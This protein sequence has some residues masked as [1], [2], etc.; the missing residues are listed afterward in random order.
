MSQQLD[1]IP[2]NFL[3]KWQGIADL[4]A[5]VIDVPAALIMKTDNEF[6]EV[7][8]SSQSENNP[9][10]PGDK[11][12]WYGL[13]CETVIKTQKALLVPNALKDEKWNKNPDIKLGMISYLGVP[14]NYPDKQPFGTLCVLDKKENKFSPENKALLYQFKN[15]IELDLALIQSLS[16]NSSIENIDIVQKLKEQNEE[17]LVINEELQQSNNQ[18]L[19]KKNELNESEKQFR[20]IV[21][22]APE[23]IFIQTEM[24][25]AYINK[26]GLELFGAKA[27]E[28]LLGTKI[29]DRVYEDNKE[30]A[31]QRITNLNIHKK[32]QSSL[33]QVFVKL[34]GTKVAVETVGIPYKYKGKDGALVF[35]RDVTERKKAEEKLQKQSEEY[36]AL[37]EEYKTQNEEISEA[38]E[39]VEKSEKKLRHFHDLM[40]YIIEHSRSAIAVHDKNYRYIYVSQR[41]LQDYK[42]KEKDIIGKH[43]YEVFPDLPQKWREVHKK[44]LAGEVSSAEDDPYYKEDGTIEWTRW[45]CRPWYEEDHSIGGFIV[46]TEVITKQKNFELELKNAK[47]KAEEANRL[48]TE[49]LN[50][51][52]HEIRTPMNGIIGFSELL[53]EP[54][55]NDEQRKYHIKIIQNSCHQLLRII[56]DILAISKL[57]TRQEKLNETEFCFND[58][59]MEI[60]SIFNLKSKERK[61]PV[62]VYKELQ[63]KESYVISDKAKLNTILSNL[64]ENAIRFTSQ[65]FIEFGYF[66]EK[67][68]LVLY[69]KDTGIGIAPENHKIIFE[70]FSQED[71]ELSRKYGGLG[72]GLSIA[73]EN[74][75]LL[76]GDITLESEKGKG[77]TFYVTIPYKPVNRTS[78]GQKKDSPNDS[79]RLHETTI[80]I[81]EDEEINF[82]YLEIL[83]NKQSQQKYHIIRAK[84]GREA[85]DICLKN[86]NIQLVLMDLKMPV[87]NGLEA[88]QKIKSKFPDLPVIAQT[89]Y[90]TDNDKDLAL[91]YG[92]DDF[93]SKPIKK[94]S[95]FKLINKYLNTNYLQ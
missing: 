87:M 34:D 29:L 19:I 9:Y 83:F 31:G 61:F 2:D 78:G 55:L 90:S 6:M 68:N 1:D 91:E 10:H 28:Q 81:A 60:F 46:Y 35:A 23:A 44:A 45:E 33:N 69:V 75:L 57:E 51:M 24:K 22:N 52:S 25:F 72:L 40:Q 32:V 95:L 27:H 13:Y 73:K 20:Q 80:L 41:Y 16:L 84:D 43:H 14:I 93:I 79:K 38:K 15:V 4:L 67:T 36:Y 77:A 8:I 70:R 11:E 21:E 62:Y 86:R 94:E 3:E 85:Y 71:K 30:E 39:R 66:I 53:D 54:E 76:G 12:Q 56:D 17:Y 47:E 58:F 89:A 49:F 92:C 42:I 74:T 59:I 7:F 50:N 88:T 64:L 63:D 5:K 37:Y 82:L 18:L 65:G 48:K 26:K